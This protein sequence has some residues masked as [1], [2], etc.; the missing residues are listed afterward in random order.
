M[1]APE[2]VAVEEAPAIVE[3]Q[4]PEPHMHMHVHEPHAE[5][6]AEVAPAPAPA[7]K[8]AAA[9]RRA[10]KTAAKPSAPDVQQEAVV[11]AEAVKSVRKSSRGG[12]SRKTV[13]KTSEQ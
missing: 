13:D 9:P 10:R 4:L 1:P 3:P 5:A 6:E 7:R 2:P 12:R 8:R 11:E